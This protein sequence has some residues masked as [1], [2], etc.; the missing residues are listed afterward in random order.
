[1]SGELFINDS[2][3]IGNSPYMEPYS[4]HFVA[5][6]DT[7]AN[8]LWHKKIG[9]YASG[10]SVTGQMDFAIDGNNSVYVSSS[11]L[12][13]DFFSSYYLLDSMRIDSGMYILKLDAQGSIS[14]L[15]QPTQWNNAQF[16]DISLT[17]DHQNNLY[18]AGNFGRASQ[19]ITIGAFS[20]GNLP[21][22]STDQFQQS[23]IA[24]FDPNGNPLWLDTFLVDMTLT[25]IEFANNQELYL[26]SYKNPSFYD[27]QFIYRMDL[28]GNL[29]KPI[30]I[31]SNVPEDD[32]FTE[33]ALASDGY[34]ISGGYRFAD[35]GGII[36]SRNESSLFLAK[37]DFNDSL[38]Y[39][40]L[41]PDVPTNSPYVQSLSVNDNDEV[42]WQFALRCNSCTWVT[43]GQTAYSHSMMKLN[44]QGTVDCVTE[45]NRAE[46]SANST[47]HFSLNTFGSAISSQGSYHFYLGKW[48]NN[49]YNEWEKNYIWHT[50]AGSTK[51]LK[52]TIFQVFPNPVTNQL[53]LKTER[54]DIFELQYQIL[55]VSGQV[56]Q[57]G[58]INPNEN[59]GIALEDFAGGIY[60]LRL[61]SD[62]AMETLKFV[63][64]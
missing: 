29:I 5:M 28:N 45:M 58:I 43:D 9:E 14:H 16:H 26:T 61:Q 15:L 4:W 3:T 62:D 24:K 32:S 36:S 57:N 23:F 10:F 42:F 59:Q 35:F 25:D 53:F 6:L 18:V 17:T 50:F 40:E 64:Y 44:S 27:N 63:K 1:M 46:V 21:P 2:T 52:T 7:A 33:F 19:A 47:H 41:T 37:Y 31:A 22:L 8:Y 54:T 12:I 39:L 51:D 55:S 48:N 38:I 49:C 56:V 34:W 20:F 13:N 60:F 11:T 30:N